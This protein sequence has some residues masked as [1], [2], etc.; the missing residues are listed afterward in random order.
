MEI[1]PLKSYILFFAGSFALS[2]VL[3][4]LVKKLALATGQ[5]A[6]PK[7]SRWHRKKTALLGGISIFVAMLTVWFLAA[8][9]VDWSLY[10]RPYLPMVICFGAIT[11]YNARILS[12]SSAHSSFGKVRKSML[13][14]R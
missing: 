3:T 5:V 14:L 8:G 2:L 9:F 4:P 11:S 1:L 13:S 6:V 10:G 12:T 7:D